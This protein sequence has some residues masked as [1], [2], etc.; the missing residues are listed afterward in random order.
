[1][2]AAY[3]GRTRHFHVKVQ[4]PGRSVLTTQIYFPGDAANRRDP[5]FRDDLAMRKVAGEG[6]FDFVIEA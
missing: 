1:V 3:P 2:P 6:R 4:A 5:L